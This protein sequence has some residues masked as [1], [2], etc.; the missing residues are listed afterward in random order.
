MQG[1]VESPLPPNRVRVDGKQFAVGRERFRFSGVTYGTFRPRGDGER[2]PDRDRIKR[3]FETMNEAGF[4]VVRTYTP[5]PD[6]ILAAAADW[7]LRLMAGVFW[8]DW[9]YLVG[10]SRRQIR[11]VGQEARTEVRRAV[12]R[13]AGC[14]Q[15]LALVLGNEV[16]AD[17]VRWLGVRTISRVLEELAEVVREEDPSMLVTYANYPS[18]EYLQVDGLDFLTFNVFLEQRHDFRAYLTRLHNLAGDRPLVLGETGL[19][20]GTT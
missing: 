2:F 5:P 18:A 12:R 17:V 16:P 19:D 20:A 7:G 1:T 10:A 14:E 9:R 15:V 13:L 11:R 8:P 3:D 6:D 4:T